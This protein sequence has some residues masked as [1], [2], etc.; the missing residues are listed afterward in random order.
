VFIP[1]FP[2]IMTVQRTAHSLLTTSSEWSLRVVDAENDF[3][4]TVPKTLVVPAG[5]DVTFPITIDAHTVPIGQVRTATLELWHIVATRRIL[6]M[7]I[8]IVRNQ[9][10]VPITKTC[11]SAT[12][13]VG[14]TSN[15]TISASNVTSFESALIDVT[16]TVP[17]NLEVVPSSVSGATLT[18]N[19]L[20][21]AGS[22]AGVQA[23]NVTIA[24]GASPA[25]GYLPL[26]LF[27]IA[28]IDGVGDETIVNFDV[29]AFT[30]AGA[31]Y[32]RLG[33]VSDGYVV[34][35]GGT[36]Q[37]VEFINQNLPNT[38]RP[39]N[40]LAAFWTDLN[41]A[42]AG[43]L[44]MGTI[45]DGADTWIV[46][47]FEAVREFSQPRTA[48]FQI[49]IGVNND[50]NPAED[51]TYAYGT[52]QGNGDGGF[53][54]VGAENV[55]GNRGQ[56]RYFNG[57]GTLPVNGTQLRVTG[58]A[59]APGGTHTITFQ[60]KGV[61]AGAWTNYAFMTSNLFQ[62]TAVAFFGGVVTK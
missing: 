60:V 26:R 45:T 47:D 4:V 6:H 51:I 48:S 54:T 42:S 2:G 56:N 25:G 62:G 27:G 7:P 13:P 49:W 22:V 39:N 55:F 43:A 33:V 20:H 16:D 15:C 1:A 21:F 36:A 37:D 32:T 14:G 31:T 61:T 29:P 35:G 52:L 53:L 3:V 41:P 17:D 12:F 30:Y 8:T 59:G 57:T 18:G 10:V 28:P 11:T 44:R 5:G 50:A 23:P 34:V 38:A 19:T 40:V 58:T 46:V 24:P 9:P